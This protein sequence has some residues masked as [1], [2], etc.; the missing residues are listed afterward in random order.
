[1][2]P[3]AEQMAA[4]GCEAPSPIAGGAGAGEAV[5]WEF[6]LPASA[7]APRGLTFHQFTRPFRAEIEEQ[8]AK[9]RPGLE[10]FLA[11]RLVEWKL[12]A[13]EGAEIE[14]DLEVWRRR[15]RM[16]PDRFQ[17]LWQRV[18]AILPLTFSGGRVK[19]DS[20][21]KGRRR[22][23]RLAEQR[24]ARGVLGSASKHFGDSCAAA[25]PTKAWFERFEAAARKLHFAQELAR[26]AGLNIQ[27]DGASK[28]L[29]TAA[30][31][32]TEKKGWRVTF[33]RLEAVARKLGVSA[34]RARELW[35][36]MK[37]RRDLTMR[38][39]YGSLSFNALREALL[40]TLHVREWPELLDDPG[41]LRER[42]GVGVD[43]PAAIAA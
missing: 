6:E 20:V 35:R 24:S 40:G 21:D 15:L 10:R 37:V 28:N 34:D 29:E 23:E 11:W 19:W 12:E 43:P 14:V 31:R 26:E 36:D 25:E 4:W 3:S 18:R 17:D 42:C 30:E 33:R 22:A 7:P 2:T 41:R 16:R 8:I 1:M 27:R 38:H 13:A 32:L 39:A 9:L 5:L